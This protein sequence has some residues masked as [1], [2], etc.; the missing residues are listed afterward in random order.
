MNPDLAGD[1]SGIVNDGPT[2]STMLE[3]YGIGEKVRALRRGRRMGLVELGR[4]TSLSPSLLSKIERGRVCPPLGTLLRIA[5]V[6]SIGLDHFFSDD[7]HKAVVAISRAAG[8]QRLAN[9]AG[10]R[11]ATYHFESL[12]F[13]A[14]NRVSSS[15]LAHFNSDS[16]GDA[17]SHTHTGFETIYV[18]DGSL[19][20]TVG[21]Q[22]VELDRGDSVYFDS[23]IPHTYRRSGEDECRAVVLTVPL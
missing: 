3:Q 5:M 21:D 8:R 1:S 11:G 18:I 10:D 23:T 17:E 20:L 6:F 4:H 16:N 19:V 14:T 13:G 22:I 2:L 12:D 9:E 15:Y 7:R